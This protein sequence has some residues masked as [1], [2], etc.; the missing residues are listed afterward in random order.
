[1]RMHD[2]AHLVQAVHARRHVLVPLEYPFVWGEG[3]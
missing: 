1:M 2:D 3:Y